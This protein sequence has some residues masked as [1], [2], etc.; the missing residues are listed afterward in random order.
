[1]LNNQEISDQCL[2]LDSL[3]APLVLHFP[4]GPPR[5]DIFCALVSF[6]TSPESHFPGPWKLKMPVRS[7]IPDY[8]HRNC[9]EFTISCIKMPCVVTLIDTLLQFEVH[10]DVVSP[11]TASKLCPTITCAITTGLRKANLAL[12]YTNSTPSFALFCPCG[13]GDPHP[14]IIGDGLWICTLDVRVGK[15]FAPNQ[16]FWS[17]EDNALGEQAV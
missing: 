14:A 4:D 5:C 3:V 2:L 7:V 11:Q 13:K 15:E 6:L 1:M 10:V 17:M 16:I 12:G 8:L 9:I